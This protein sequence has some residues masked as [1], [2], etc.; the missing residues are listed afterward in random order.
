MH[1][2]KEPHIMVVSKPGNP[3]LTLPMYSDLLGAT[4]QALV[5][6][7]V[8]GSN[9]REQAQNPKPW[10]PSALVPQTPKYTLSPKP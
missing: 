5:K 4:T 7:E 3:V 6:V 1:N 8:V 9:L 10:Y 2:T